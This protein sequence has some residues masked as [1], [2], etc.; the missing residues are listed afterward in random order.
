MSRRRE[1]I[2]DEEDAL[3]FVK[4]GF[5]TLV[6]LSRVRMLHR[7]VDEDEA[8]EETEVFKSI[9]LLLLF[10]GTESNSESATESSTS[11]EGKVETAPTRASL[12]RY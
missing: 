2:D 6:I 7:W 8:E 11:T 10:D 1:I 5:T 4:S 12:C 3:R 9:L